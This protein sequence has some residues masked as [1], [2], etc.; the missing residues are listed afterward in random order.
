MNNQAPALMGAYRLA[1]ET[2]PYTGTGTLLKRE[3]PEHRIMVYM[4]AAGMAAKQIATALNYSPV[5]V[6]SVLR[7]PWARHLYAQIID[8]RGG[9]AVEEFLKVNAMDAGQ[10]IVD[11]MNDVTAKREVQQKSA[12][13]ILD[14]V[15]AD[16]L[17]VIR[18]QNLPPAILDEQMQ[19]IETEIR[20][21]QS[22]KFNAPPAESAQLEAAVASNEEDKTGVAQEA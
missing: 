22:G 20:E 14:K 4:R 13:F 3:Q 7:Q 18:T 10:K 9:S 11:L 19:V 15:V 16:K 8:Q 2:S 12:M 21:I 1:D 6:H 5:V 17:D